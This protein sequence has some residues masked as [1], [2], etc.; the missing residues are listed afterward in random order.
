M[1]EFTTQHTHL[2]QSKPDNGFSHFRVDV[3]HSK[4]L[5]TLLLL[6]IQINT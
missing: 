6:A 5:V 4:D 3:P 2:Y 1:R